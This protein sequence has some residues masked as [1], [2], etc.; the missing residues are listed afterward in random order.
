MK[1]KNRGFTLIEITAVVLILGVIFLVSYPTLENIL[2]KSEK[3]QLSVDEENIILAAK[4]YIN[5]HS[6]EYDFT[7]GS[8]LSV[9]ITSLVEDELIDSSDN[10]NV[11]SVVCEIASDNTLNCKIQKFPIYENGTVIYYN[12]ETNNVCSKE[13]SE[14]NVNENGTSM[15]IKTG[16]MK[17][18]TFNDTSDALTVNMILDHNTTPLVDWNSNNDNTEMLEVAEA[19]ALDTETWDKEIKETVR[20]MK[21]E[22]V[23]KITGNMNFKL[24][25]AASDSWFFLDSND[26]NAV[27][28]ET[29]KSNYAWL[30]NNMYECIQYGCEIED[31]NSFVLY[32]SN[33]SDMIYGYWLS[34]INV[35]STNEV[36]GITRAG[37][38]YSNNAKYDINYGWGIRPVITVDK[39]IIS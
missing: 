2:N 31:N 4:T 6:S 19:L 33:S 36:W 5:K 9:Q 34:S 1:K 18:Y 8:K 16:C 7:V 3:D 11:N 20:L 22:E 12:P 38:T 21:V 23:A 39:A 26:Q 25:E 35:N 15:G 13:E 10:I 14:A 29:N 24:T 27:A 28:S 30:F 17:W 37:R 32:N